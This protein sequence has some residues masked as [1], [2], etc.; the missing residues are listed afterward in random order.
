MPL[1]NLADKSILI[2]DDFPEMRSL[3]RSTVTSFGAGHTE[4]AS[5]GEDAIELLASR[6]FDIVLCDYNLGEGKD[7][8]QVL[9]EISYRGLMPRSTTFV[10]VTA[11][12]TSQM[13]MGALEYQPDAYIAKPVTRTVLQMRLQ[14]LLAKKD[15][16]RD[17]YSALDRKRYDRTIAACEHHLEQGSKYRFELLKIKSEVLIRTGAY[18][19]AVALCET[20]LEERDLP[21]ARFDLGR[22]HYHRQEH[23][24]AGE[25][26]SRVIA[27]NSAFVSAYDWLARTQERLGDPVAAQQTLVQA[28]EQSS[29]SLL[30]LRAL[31]TVAE[32]NQDG[33]VNEQARRKAIRVGRGSVLRQPSD[34]TGLARAL[35]ANN[36]AKDALKVIDSIK[37]EFRDDPLAELEATA[38]GCSVHAALGNT[39]LSQTALDRAIE[40][41]SDSPELL[42]ADLGTELARACLAHGRK[43][44]A[45]EFTRRV[46]VNNHDNQTVLDRITSVYKEA[47]ALAEINEL[48]DST[49]SE[50]VRINNEGVRLLNDGKIRESIALFSEAVKGMPHNPII[51]LN[52]AQSLISMMK[53]S[54]PTKSALEE[55]L[56]YIRAASD[57]DVHKE[58]QCQLLAECRELS[59]CL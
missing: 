54:Q 53:D 31:A 44:A 28:V 43:D 42:S 11:E 45:D 27:D 23:G 1:W 58:R 16:L 50:I 56:S 48:I 32:K 18:D 49:R 24:Q 30:R 19:R 46:V 12:N 3:M 40:L 20:V 2:I 8:Q 6:R 21:W 25:I 17:I 7:G 26:F 51:N 37:Y 57:S 41:A 47:G 52:A 36:A 13:V 38:A 39:E 55:T 29:K 33:A 10:M 59:S 35:V 9:E 34:Y 22:I 5:N 4:M 15:S 14:K